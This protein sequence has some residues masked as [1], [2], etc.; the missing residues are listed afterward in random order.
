MARGIV[1]SG[2]FTSSAGTV[3]DSSPMKAHNVRAAAAVMPP[4]IP[5]PVPSPAGANG[6]K[7]PASMKNRP[8]TPITASGTNFRT[9]VSSCRM[10]LSRTPRMLTAVSSQI[11][12]IVTPAAARLF[13]PNPGKNTVR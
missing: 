11:T 13:V 7:L 2:S 12:P 6:V 1:R 5:S 3:A 10:P 9:V 8:T 4:S